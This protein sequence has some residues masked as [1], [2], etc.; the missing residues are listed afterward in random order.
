MRRH[1]AW[2]ML[3]LWSCALCTPARAHPLSP[4][5]LELVEEAPGRYQL[6]FRRSS[7]A[8]S[9]LTLE[10]PA[11]CRTGDTRLERTGDALTE[12]ARLTCARTL[13]GRRIAVRGL[14]DLSLG[15][16]V[17]LR[18]R[19][20]RSA[21]ALLDGGEPG[22]TVPQKT[23]KAEV[24]VAYLALGI[25]HLLTGF[26]HLLFVAGLLAIVRGLRAT[27]LALSAFTLGHSVT[28]C[29]A[30][31]SIVR[32]PLPPVELG[33]ALSLLVLAHELTRPPTTSQRAGWPLFSLV[34]S[35]GLLHGLGFAGALAE[36]GL[37]AHEI[38]LS[39]LAFNLG[40]EA[41]QV[42]ACMALAPVLLLSHKIA[43]G[44]ERLIRLGL[45][46]GIGTAAAFW[47]IERTLTLFQRAA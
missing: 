7:A 10:L 30:A 22:L 1:F 35:L 38:P 39:L 45:A 11:D 27:L 31:L 3:A 14:A 34:A 33:I 29:L 44:D 28:L 15:A 24:F 8:F 23:T 32:M 5:A 13:E 12:H 16:L 9:L 37:P 6:S 41:G 40:V 46:Y 21:Q 36:V 26:D 25:E 20:G 18:F 2:A 43:R 47:C 42:I 4:A 17:S 19:D